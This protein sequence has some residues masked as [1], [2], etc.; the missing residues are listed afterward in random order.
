MDPLTDFSAEEMTFDGS[1]KRVFWAG[2]GPA[3]VIMTEMPGITPSVADFAR[4]LVHRG[5]SVA[6]P[7]LFG[8]AGREP[9]GGYI[10][11]S[12]IKGCVSK[13]FVAFA[14]QKTSPVVRWVRQ[15]AV[16]AHRRC[17]GTGVGVVGM[18]FTGGFALAVAVEPIVD[19]AVLSQ[20]SL[21]LPLGAKRRADLGLNTA[22]RQAVAARADAG[23]LCAIGLRFTQDPMVRPERF[24]ALRELLGEAFIGVEID[25]SKGNP[26]G[27]SAKAHSVLTEEYTQHRS[28]THDAYELVVRHLSERLLGQVP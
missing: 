21:P 9:S 26:D 8:E 2:D 17:G 7:D 18:C 13:E 10:A 4:R 1:A 27:F 14:T 22:D 19:V 12:V 28:P 11:G 15:L 6:L 24:E 5:F 3:V 23:Q 16:E 20:P 25:S